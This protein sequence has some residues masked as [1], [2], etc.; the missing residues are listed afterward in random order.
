MSTSEEADLTSTSLSCEPFFIRVD[1]VGN[2]FIISAGEG[3]TFVVQGDGSEQDI[4]PVL[5]C[6][7]TLWRTK[8]RQTAR[9]K[10]T[11]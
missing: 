4:E 8:R 1:G 7:R 6:I 5:A 9:R 10:T 11:P 2:G 3:R